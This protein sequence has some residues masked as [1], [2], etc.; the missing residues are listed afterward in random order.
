M[1]RAKPQWRRVLTGRYLRWLV[2]RALTAAV[3]GLG[4]RLGFFPATVP[5]MEAG[6]EVLEDGRIRIQPDRLDDHAFLETATLHDSTADDFDLAENVTSGSRAVLLSDALIE[7]TTGQ[8]VLPHRGSVVMLRGHKANLNATSARFR[9]E[10]VSLPGRAWSP[11][12]TQNYYHMLVD[13]GLR[14][15]EAAEHG[16]MTIVTTEPTGRVAGALWRGIVSQLPS[17]KLRVVADGALVAA[18]EV[19][20]NFP[21]NNNWEWTP[22]PPARAAHLSSVF[23]SSYGPPKKHGPLLYLSRGQ[24]KLR[25]PTNLAQMEELL[26]GHGF[27]P[28]VATDANHPEQ[29]SRFASAEIV[30]SI[31]G[32]GLTNLLFARPGTKV[33]EV[34]PS[35]F[36]KST[37]WW[38]AHELGMEHH[39]LIGGLGDYDQHFVA[40]L[41][42]L[43]AKLRQILSHRH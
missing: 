11:V 39:P 29:I 10:R 14:A 25:Q 31:H 37:F 3:P 15:I 2:L 19:L 35:N 12:R 6:G 4:R 34:F 9:R 22:I 38:M 13:N 43:T 30:V 36:V 28:F 21:D 17:T 26:A 42:E 16:P 1:A 8:V 41:E 5:M 27:Q 18:D 7:A 32:A 20:V 40:P 24:S 33:V 23:Q